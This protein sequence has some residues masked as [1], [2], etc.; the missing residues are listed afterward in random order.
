MNRYILFIIW[1]LCH[2]MPKGVC[3]Q[4]FTTEDSLQKII[5]IDEMLSLADENSLALRPAKTSVNE[6]LQGIKTARNALLPEIEASVSVSYIGNG[7]MWDRHFSDKNKAPMP[8]FGNN[9]TIEASQTVYSGGA[10]SHNITIARLQSENA[11][12]ELE[13]NRNS[14]RFMLVSYYLDLFK[15]RNIS[16]V[17]KLNISQ[18]QQVLDELRIKEAEGIILHNDITRYELQLANLELELSRIKNSIRIANQHLTVSLG[19]PNETEIIPDTMLLHNGIGINDEYIWTQTALEQSPALKQSALAIEMEKHK[20]KIVRSERI[21]KIAIFAGD[22]LD[23]P[24]LIEVPPIDKNFNY[25]YVGIGVKYNFDALFK[26]QC[27][28]SRSKLSIQRS[29]EAYDYAKEQTE[30]AISSEYIRF[31]ECF[32]TLDTRKKSVELANR[33]YFVVHHRYQN[34]MALITDMLDAGNAKLSAEV[35]LANAQIDI[36]FNYYKLRYISGTL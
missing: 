12:W 21:P 18:T 4:S 35:D 26:S 36:I 14:I 16:N 5:T 13:E 7:T 11:R 27:N 29:R 3:A 24:I 2:I 28:L 30:L 33:N 17:Y 23:G 25:W 1:L 34:E 6:T 15:L 8:H 32:Q 31:L 22:I 9:F 10:I 19:L 20:E